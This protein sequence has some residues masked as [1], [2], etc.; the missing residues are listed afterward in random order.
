MNTKP[1]YTIVRNILILL[2]PIFLVLPMQAKAQDLVV[3]FLKGEVIYQ[4][5]N[6]EKRGLERGDALSANDRIKLEEESSV[7]LTDE[8]GK[9]IVIDKKGSYKYSELKKLLD[10]DGS[11]ITSK[12]FA[13]VWKKINKKKVKDPDLMSQN[14]VG[15]V[16]RSDDAYMMYP[17]N[18][19][20]MVQPII[21]FKWE[22]LPKSAYFIITDM[23]NNVLLKIR[24]DETGLE[25]FPFESG[26]KQ[27]ESYRWIVSIKS[28]TENQ[29]LYE[30]YLPDQEWKEEYESEKESF[31][32]EISSIETGYFQDELLKE[33]DES[34]GIYQYKEISE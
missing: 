21:Q 2:A 22:E 10:K 12:Y 9:H 27:G 17:P 33:F 30:F 34:W 1:L 31:L 5:S 7:A 28:N 20:S 11:D 6:A 23:D 29:V 15:G 16:S 19:A 26:L 8:S 25:L 18:G 3:Y 24:S 4:P 32:K 14:V 13:Y